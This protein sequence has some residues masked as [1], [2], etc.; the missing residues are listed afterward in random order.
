M[1]LDAQQEFMVGTRMGSYQL[2]A[3]LGAGG[4]GAVY[5]AHHALLGRPAAVK[6]LLPEMSQNRDVVNRFFNEARAATAI[7]HPSIVEIY[8]FGFLADGNAYIVMELLEGE[9]LA[10]RLARVGVPPEERALQVT[11]QIAGALQAAHERQIVHRDLKPDNVFVVRDPEIAGGERIKLLDFGIA[12]LATDVGDSRTRT[13]TVM[14]T[15]S[16]MAPEQC[17][18]AS[19]VDG[20][21]DLY[22]LGCIL[23]ELLCGRPPFVADGPG[24]VIAHHLYFAPESPRL[25][26]PAIS[27][28]AEALAMWLLQKDPAARPA[29]AGEVITAIDALGLGALPCGAPSSI[30]AP[31]PAPAAPGASLALGTEIGRA[32]V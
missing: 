6:I 5:L 2:V 29:T 18:G 11:R 13:G 3:P 22:A 26:R 25:L 14:G 8:D 23:Y 1:T 32:H 21:A 27:E 12:K 7:R 10:R 15:P 30:S 28:G 17:R 20:R 9:S 4:M 31:P 19:A 16:Y 24:D